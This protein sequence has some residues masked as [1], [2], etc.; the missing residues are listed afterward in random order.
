MIRSMMRTCLW[1]GLL[2][3]LTLSSVPGAEIIERRGSTARLNGEVTAVDKNVVKFKNNKGELIDIPVGEVLEIQWTGEPA[4]L[5]TARNDEGAGRLPK[6]LDGYKK[7]ATENKAPSPLVKVDIQYF[8]ARAAA[9]LALSDP[10]L[11]AEAIK[12]LTDFQGQNGDS[13]HY[14]EAAD[15]LVQLNLLSGDLA[16]ARTAAES[17]GKSTA[18]AYKMGSQLALGRV[19]LQENKLD[20]AQKEFAAVAAMTAAGPLEESRKSEAQMGLARVMGLQNKAEDAIK[21]L[22]EVIQKSAAEDSRLQ[23]EAFLR[24][25]DAYQ[26]AGKTKDALLS[27]LY[28]DV[29]TPQEKSIHPEAL[30]HLSQLWKISQQPERAAEAAERLTAEY[31]NSP[32]TAKLK[33]TPGA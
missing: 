28:V 3:G 21:L 4:D 1:V 19:L 32:W 22:E 9:K 12:G 30:Y 2:G 10:K 14:F 29:V 17:L 18:S 6:S 25:G 20:E 24:L 13:R 33:G 23:A 11:H 5:K 26:S 7:A 16:A 31:P 27:Y 15:Y 8:T